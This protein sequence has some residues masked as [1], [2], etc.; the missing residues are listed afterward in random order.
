MPG[1]PL[2]WDLAVVQTLLGGTWGP[3][4][5]PVMPSWESRAVIGGSGLCVQGSGVPPWR[6]GPNDTSWG[7]SSFLATWC[8]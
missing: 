5:G 3:S 1:F 7:V 8:P 2:S 6:S 4:E